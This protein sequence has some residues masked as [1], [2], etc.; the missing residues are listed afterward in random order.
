VGSGRSGPIGRGC[1]DGGVSDRPLGGTVPRLPPI[2]GGP[3]AGRRGHA[4][5][6]HAARRPQRWEK[7]ARVL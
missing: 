5:P 2:C 1:S 7:V 6:E 3:R 4:R